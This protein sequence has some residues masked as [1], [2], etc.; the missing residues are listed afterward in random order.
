MMMH[1]D[2]LALAAHCAQLGAKLDIELSMEVAAGERH[3]ACN[4]C[5]AWGLCV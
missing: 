4:A 5:I 2:A 1:A 3:A